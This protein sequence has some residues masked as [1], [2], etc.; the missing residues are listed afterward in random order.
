MKEK[1]VFAIVTLGLLLLLSTCGGLQKPVSVEGRQNVVHMSASDF[2]FEPNNISTRVGD[3]ITFRIENTSGS[4]HNF[5]L[6][7]PEGNT[8]QGIDILPKQSVDVTATFSKAGTYKFH[9][10]KTGHSQLGMKG[11]VV[12]LED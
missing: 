11:Q 3:T 1:M 8:M 9:C 7:D 5:T 10:N 6:V 12:A 4:M 2:K